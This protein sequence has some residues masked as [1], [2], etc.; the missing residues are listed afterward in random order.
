VVFDWG[1]SR[2]N[3]ESLMKDYK[4]ATWAAEQLK[5]RDFD[6]KPFFMAIGISKPHFPFY[7]PQKHY[8]KYPME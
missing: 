4:T 2:G 5:T 7:V 6:G 1:P 3:D 8:D